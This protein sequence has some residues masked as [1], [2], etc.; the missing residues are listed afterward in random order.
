MTETA[1][2]F[3]PAGEAALTVEFGTTIDPLLN[4]RVRGLDAALAASP[5][6]GVIETVPTYRSLMIH[7]DPRVLSTSALIEKLARLPSEPL[8]AE[9]GKHWLIP[10]CYDA[11]HA[12]DLAEV[13]KALAMTQDEIVALH[14][15]AEYQV[16][17]YGFAP[18]YVFLSG[19]PAALN[20]SRRAKPRPPIPRGSLLIA[21]GQALIGNDPMPTGWYHIGR[22]PVATFDPEREP[23]CFIEVGDRIHF[24]AIDAANFERLEQAARDGVP[25][26]R[27]LA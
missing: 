25:I 8:A 5:I 2:R 9:S 20:I 3:L 17:M 10:V 7:F 26:A 11:T 13:A 1:P 22:T 14:R 12:E 27:R 16:I 4:A 24:E 18:G 21:G 19:L 6:A 23:P 15:D